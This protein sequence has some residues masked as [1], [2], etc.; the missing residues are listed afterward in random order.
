[1]GFA[2]CG[3]IGQVQA[4]DARFGLVRDRGGFDLY[5]DRILAGCG[6][7]GFVGVLDERLL[8]DRHIVE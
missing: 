4:D 5:D 2:Q 6:L 1:M 7:H 3:L 8:H